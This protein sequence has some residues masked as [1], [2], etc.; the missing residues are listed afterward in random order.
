MVVNEG[1]GLLQVKSWGSRFYARSIWGYRYHH[2]IYKG[3]ALPTGIEGGLVA[4]IEGPSIHLNDSKAWE[5]RQCTSH[6]LSLTEVPRLP[7]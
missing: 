3:V 4:A 6:H 2:M 7:S 5:N 1:G